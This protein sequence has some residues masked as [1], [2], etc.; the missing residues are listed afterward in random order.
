MPFNE[1]SPQDHFLKD[2][3]KVERKLLQQREALNYAL[4]RLAVIDPPA[5]ERI[6]EIMRDES[7]HKRN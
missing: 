7:N 3:K 6:K 4:E 5:V 1:F 2:L